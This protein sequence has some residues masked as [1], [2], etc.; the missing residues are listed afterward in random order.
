MPERPLA[1]FITFTTYGTWLHGKDPGSVDRQHNEP[2]TPLLP[3][4]PLQELEEHDAMDQPAYSLDQQR[5]QVVLATIQEVCRHRRWRLLAC[6]VRTVH[7]HVVVAAD[8]PPEKILNDFKAYASRRLTEA[9]YE[10]KERKRWTRHGSTKYI[11]DE[12][13]LRNAIHYTLYEQGEPMETYLAPELV[14]E[15]QPRPSEPRP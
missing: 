1:F 2:E 12:E 3:G 4:N 11:W 13:Y 9:G 14:S 5:R 10:N 8:A 7:V 15:C 6:H